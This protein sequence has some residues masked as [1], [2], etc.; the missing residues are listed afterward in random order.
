MA[1][2]I[3][4]RGLQTIPVILI[5]TF[6]VF[7][8]M[9]LVGNPVRLLLPEDADEQ[10]IARLKQELGFDQPVLVRYARFLGGALRGDFGRSFRHRAPAFGLVVER[11][12]VTL[13]LSAYALLL[14]VGMAVPLGV[15]SAVRRNSLVD[16][17]ATGGAVLGRAMPNFW[18][19]IMLILLVAVQ[20]RLVPVSGYSTWK[21]MVLPVITLGTGLAAI[22]T[23]LMRSSLLEVIRQDYMTTARSKGLAERVVIYKHG[24]RNAL[25]P[26]VTVLGVQAAELVE[27]AVITETVFAIPGMGRLTVQALNTLDFSIVQTGV[28]LGSV[29]VIVINLAVDVLYT[30]IDPRIRYS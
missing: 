28:I 20:W 4:R 2:F 9:N 26:V 18:L 5:V 22:L 21:H 27:G 17:F 14:A 1:G 3:A 19:G 12:P 29:V 23:R 24:V 30:F 13:K 8:L 11:M 25:I 15:I 6:I 7:V 16:L 10:D